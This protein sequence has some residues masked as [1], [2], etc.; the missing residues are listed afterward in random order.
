M[1]DPKETSHS[2]ME[3]LIQHLAGWVLYP[4][5]DLIGQVIMGD[6]S[7]SRY[8]TITVVGG[9][10]YRFEIP[11]WF[12]FLDRFRLEKDSIQKHRLLR[13]FVNEATTDGPFKF[14]WLGKTIGAALFFNP[15]WIA[16]HLFFIAVATTPFHDINWIEILGSTLRAG[17]ISFLTNLPICII[18]N[19]FI[20]EHL[21]LKYRFLGSALLTTLLNIK[22]AMEFMLLTK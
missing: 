12:G 21:S 10:L 2:S 11:K 15:L 18:G 1:S 4:L 17:S 8:I 9:V 6:P 13:Y 22:Y 16:R 19:Y 7:L 20:Q 3:T 5:G 14:N